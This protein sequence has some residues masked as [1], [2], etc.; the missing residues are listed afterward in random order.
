[1]YFGVLVGTFTSKIFS[2]SV[3]VAALL[4]YL[5][6]MILQNDLLLRAACSE[7]LERTP[8]WTMRKAGRDIG[9]IPRRAQAGRKPY[10]TCHYPEASGLVGP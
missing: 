3:V 9:R 8:V 2:L 7:R 10:K 4:P 1:M 6:G 5:C